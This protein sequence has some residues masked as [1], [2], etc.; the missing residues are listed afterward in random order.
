MKKQ[1]K[2]TVLAFRAD[3]ETASAAR[4]LAEKED[5]PMGSMLRTLIK[6]AIEARK[7]Q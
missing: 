4:S 3:Q 2:G 5:R 6:E 7:K 1:P